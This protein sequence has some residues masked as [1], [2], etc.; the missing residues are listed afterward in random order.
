MPIVYADPLKGRPREASRIPAPTRDVLMEQFSQ[1]FEENP[2]AAGKRFYELR[3]QERNGTPIAADKA[4]QQLRASGMESELQVDD[5]GITQEALDTLM[6]RKRVELRRRDILSRAQG[7]VGETVGRFGVAAA[8]TLADPLSAGLNFVP[9]VGQ[10]KYARWLGAAGGAAGRVGVRAAV[11]AA[12][13]AVGAAIVEPLIYA[14]RTAEQADYDAVD[15]LLNVAFGGFTGTAMHTT[16]GTLGEVLS[17]SRAA[18][19][20]P[21]AR[22]SAATTAASMSPSDFQA[23]VRAAVGQAAEGRAVDVDSVVRAATRV[24]DEERLIQRQVNQLLE[25]REGQ[26]R[27]IVEGNEGLAV[28]LR[29]ADDT[30]VRLANAIAGRD[31]DAAII[32]E[33]IAAQVDAEARRLVGADHANAYA[34]KR[35]REQGSEGTVFEKWRVRAGEIV[36]E[37][38][39]LAS[40]RVAEA[41]KLIASLR[42][43]TERLNRVRN[44]ETELERIRYSKQAAKTIDDLVD[45]LPS[46]AQAGFLRRIQSGRESGDVRAR[47]SALRDEAQPTVTEQ[48]VD[49]EVAETIARAEEVLAREP[50]TGTP[51]ENALEMATEEAAL[52]EADLKAL[53]ERLGVDLKDDA[54]DA[55][56]EAV[57]ASERWAKTAELA[58]VCLMRGG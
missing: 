56:N 37:R 44:A 41:N 7:G 8:T 20:S 50:E 27:A 23:A 35:S 15:S 24:P 53:S 16:V 47:G 10:A 5:A 36:G 25:T 2:I 3:Q 21:A 17:R 18:P 55:V 1:T 11:G 42:E 4:R 26:M 54:Y 19:V 52:A 40:E 58:T 29:G 33:S 14:S 46:D 30:E 49:N 22:P 38:R 6:E 31:A 34:I 43:V 9:V 45:A 51:T 48:P 12:E 32:A 28:R 13:G 57:K 39:R